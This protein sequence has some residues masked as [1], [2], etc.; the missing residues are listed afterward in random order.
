MDWYNDKTNLF[1]LFIK[2]YNSNISF[3]IRMCYKY[4]VEDLF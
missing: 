4:A 1:V 3:K 2:L